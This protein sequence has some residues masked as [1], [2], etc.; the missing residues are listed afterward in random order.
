M[1]ALQ[2]P[3]AAAAQ[4]ALLQAA[5]PQAAAPQPSVSNGKYYGTEAKDILT[6]GDANEVFYG[7]GAFDVLKGGAGV[8]TLV[9]GKARDYGQ[10]SFAAGD[11]GHLDGRQQ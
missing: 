5:P 4:I 9:G 10:V 3:A 2:T 11:V 1:T 7:K 6:G 8:D